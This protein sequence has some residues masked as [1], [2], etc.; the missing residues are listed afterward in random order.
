MVAKSSATWTNHGRGATF[1]GRQTGRASP[2]LGPLD[3]EKEGL[4]PEFAVCPRLSLL[5]QTARAWRSAVLLRG[6]GPCSAL[7]CAATHSRVL[8][9][10]AANNAKEAG[11]P[12][13]SRLGRPRGAHCKQLARLPESPVAWWMALKARVVGLGSPYNSCRVLNF[14]YCSHVIS[15]GTDTIRET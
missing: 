8:S 14:P 10:A 3:C 1:E 6:P 7:L 9:E 2:A 15:W 13:L 12:L 5:E 11:R 4:L